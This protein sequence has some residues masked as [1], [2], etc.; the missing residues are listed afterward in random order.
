MA[1]LRHGKKKGS[2]LAAGWSHNNHLSWLHPHRN[3]QVTCI[4]GPAIAFIAK[5]RTHRIGNE[6][7]L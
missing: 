2:P 6:Q 5:L 3:V 7:R 4:H 1:P